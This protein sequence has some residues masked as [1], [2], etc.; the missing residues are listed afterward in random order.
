VKTDVV[1]A[2]DTHPTQNI[3]AS[4]ALAQDKTVKLWCVEF[5]NILFI[6]TEC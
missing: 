4:G 1:I 3:I 6:F 2:V 5:I